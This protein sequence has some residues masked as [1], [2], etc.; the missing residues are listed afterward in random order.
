MN[1]TRRFLSTAI[2]SALDFE[3][4]SPEDVIRHI[5][6]DVLAHHLPVSLKERLLT[7]ALD[8][9]VM[10]AML[11]LDTLGVDALAEH[12]P[13]H[14]LW[15]CIAAAAAQSLGKS[16]SDPISPGTALANGDIAAAMPLSPA[17]NTTPVSPS[18]KPNRSARP[19]R[20]R[21][22]ATSRS[23]LL[24][25]AQVPSP[26]PEADDSAFDVDTRV[27][28][29][30]SLNDLDVIEETVYDPSDDVTTHGHKP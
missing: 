20:V 28:G 30:P 1:E 25:P 29:D 13:A 7:A 17:T 12:A 6:M 14:L 16:S 3:V 8:A 4:M 18:R 22:G 27:G 15:E 19:S 9:D 2:A 11:V 10:N 24:P 23:T 26:V 5:T 21:A